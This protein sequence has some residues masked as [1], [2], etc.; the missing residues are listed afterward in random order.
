LRILHVV[1]TY[2]PARRYGGPI[3]SVHGLCRALARRG[4]EVAVATTNVDG[5]GDTDVPLA[6]PV[7]R[8][9]VLVHYFPSRRLRR[10]YY[11]PPLREFLVRSM[12]GWD[13]VHTHSVFLWPT[14]AA[15]RLARKSGKPY[16]V[17]PRGMLVESLI[18][19]RSTLAKR[20]WIALFERRNLREAA[21]VHVTSEL[22]R[23]DL[24]ALGLETR[25][26]VEVPNGFDPPAPPDPATDA[27]AE[28]PERYALFLGRLT[29]KKG[30]EAL[31]ES[32][33]EAPGIDLVIAGNDEEGLRPRLE[34]LAARLGVAGR[35]RFEGYVEGARKQLLLERA[36]FLVLPS[37]SENFGNV[38]IEAMAAGTPV[39]VSPE[40]GAAHAVQAA[41]AGLVAPAEPRALALA[42]AT[43]AGDERLRAEM[44]A[45]A[46]AAASAFTWESVAR[47]MEAAYREIV[48]E[49]SG[50]RGSKRSSS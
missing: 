32:L 7:D 34:A 25:R 30:L 23:R 46:R 1:P 26:F 31:V 40:V 42:L 17:S 48:E 13:L 24:L 12:P 11:S 33:A 16:V 49:A 15:A 21:A 37:L 29:W 45:N 38:V 14:T 18:T 5:P 2:L 4:H 41:R 22:E 3:E 36:A 8:D 50:P 9:G 20:A 39:V 6:T 19:R 28:L 35:V 10:L 27:H 44:G 47:R 43:L